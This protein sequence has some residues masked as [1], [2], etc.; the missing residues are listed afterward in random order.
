[1]FPRIHPHVSK[2]FVNLPDIPD[3]KRGYVLIPNS[4]LF[5][6]KNWNFF[7][8][9]NLQIQIP[10]E[11]LL[12][13]HIEFADSFNHLQRLIETKCPVNNKFCQTKNAISN[14]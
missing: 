10:L 8:L 5:L 7:V 6:S 13:K 14:F 12:I 4:D 3:F 1:M 11:R 9:L 2:Q